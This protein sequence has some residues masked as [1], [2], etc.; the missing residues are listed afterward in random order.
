MVSKH[1]LPLKAYFT[2]RL[3]EGLQG[4]CQN[5]QAL[6]ILVWIL[7]L[8]CTSHLLFCARSLH[9]TV[10][11][12]GRD[13]CHIYIRDQAS[14]PWKSTNLE[15]RLIFLRLQRQELA[16]THGSIELLQSFLDVQFLPNYRATLGKPRE[17]KLFSFNSRLLRSS[18]AREAQ[19]QR[20]QF[21]LWRWEKRSWRL[22][23]TDV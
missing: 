17:R 16:F 8:S 9:V 3:D 7:W 6:R 23:F 13:S 22:C 5:L 10:S 15:H 19:E 4:W 20:W 12:D 18:F 14:T 1:Y 2:P 21:D 11:S